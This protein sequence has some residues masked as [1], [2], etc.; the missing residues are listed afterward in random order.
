MDALAVLGIDDSSPEA[1]AV[2]AAF[3][4]LR[5]AVSHLLTASLSGHELIAAGRAPGEI[6]ALGR[7]GSVAEARALHARDDRS[8]QE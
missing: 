6:A 7:V 8:A 4:G 3:T 1:A 5:G 2:C